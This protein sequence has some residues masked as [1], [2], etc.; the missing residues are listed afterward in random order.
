VGQEI[1]S[2]KCLGCA[3]NAKWGTIGPVIVDQLR[4]FM[5]SILIPEMVVLGQ[6]T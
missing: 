3:Q 5:D 2:L 6:K 4:I 1:S